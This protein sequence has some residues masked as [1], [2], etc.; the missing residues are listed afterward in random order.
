MKREVKTMARKI[1][2][3]TEATGAVSAELMEDKNPKTAQAIWNSLPIEA[4]ANTWGDEIYFS[5][6]V[7]VKEENS[8]A[9]VGLGDLGYW[10]PGRAFCIFFG[11]TPVSKGDEIRPASPVNVFGLVIGDPKVFKKVQ[12]GD[13]IRVE[14]A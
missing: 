9:T 8:Q 5:T 12:D 11:P 1:K 7:K 14:R 2:I 3:V 6:P 10:P 13:K 4:R